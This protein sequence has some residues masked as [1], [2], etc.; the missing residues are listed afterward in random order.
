MSATDTLAPVRHMHSQV[1]ETERCSAMRLSLT[2]FLSLTLT[3][4]ASVC[5]WLTHIV[6]LSHS[7]SHCLC[8]SLAHS[9]RFSLSR[10][11]VMMKLEAMKS[12]SVGQ[13]RGAESDA[14]KAF[15]VRLREV[16]AEIKEERD[17]S[18]D[19]KGEWIQKTV[20]LRRELE[21]LQEV[22]I[23][24]DQQYKVRGTGGGELPSPLPQ[25]MRNS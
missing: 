10:C 3:R 7:H 19:G 2:S 1:R 11:Q 5:L 20:A 21:A 6:S 12:S 18:D 8:L 14:L 25:I 15:R 13:F 4:I 16:E 17:R 24:L 22:S 23:R 9:H